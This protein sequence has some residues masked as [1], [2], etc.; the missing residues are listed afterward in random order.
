MKDRMPKCHQKQRKWRTTSSAPTTTTLKIP[1][2]ALAKIKIGQSF[3][4]YDPTLLDPYVY[5]H[6]PASSGPQWIRT[7][8]SSS[9]SDVEELGR[10]Q[11][12]HI[13]T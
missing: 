9:L 1:K 12:A 2:G 4:E 6:T 3:A 8:A 11:S 10:P 13:A 7:V 5:V